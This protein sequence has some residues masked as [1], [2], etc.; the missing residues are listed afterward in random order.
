MSSAHPSEPLRRLNWGCGSHVAE[1]WINSDVKDTPEVDLVADIRQGLPL[2]DASI[3]YAVSVHALPELALPELVPSLSELRRVLKS[4]GVLRLV[5][6]DLD[7]GIQAYQAGDD[8]YFQVD[9]AE[10]T[11]RGGRFIFHMLWYGYSKALFTVDFVEELLRQ[12]GF[13]ESRRCRFRQTQSNFPDIVT[14][15]NREQESLFVEARK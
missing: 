4:D 5:L 12:A 9:P 11:S 3:D 10:V 15:D 14:L 13:S 1:G 7:K 6:P 8:A 2:A